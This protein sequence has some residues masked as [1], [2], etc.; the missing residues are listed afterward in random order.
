MERSL[1]NLALGLKRR[2]YDV[3]VFTTDYGGDVNHSQLQIIRTSGLTFSE[4]SN[5]IIKSL[6]N[7]INANSILIYTS[8]A[9]DMIDGI[10]DSIDLFT[11]KGAHAIFRNPT[12]D[13]LHRHLGKGKIKSIISLFDNIVSIDSKSYKEFQSFCPNKIYLIYNG[14]NIS[15]FYQRIPF[16]ER[17]SRI[18]FRSR[19]SQRKNPQMILGLAKILG[20]DVKFYI[21]IT[22]NYKEE[23]LYNRFIKEAK[24]LKN[25]K[26]ISPSWND[27]EV[28]HRTGITLLPSYSEGCSNSILESMATEHICI[29]NDIEENKH[30]LS[31]VGFTIRLE[32]SQYVKVLIDIINNPKNYEDMAIS[33]RRKIIENYS[34][35]NTIEKWIQLFSK[36]D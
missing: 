34:I 22:S 12:S 35:Q 23:N 8:L 14:V 17:A 21:Q 32:T 1:L 30:L 4:W 26:L 9:K 15:E 36:L 18:L 7:L 33:A 6:A 16:L 2:G 13:H 24:T 19:I 29:A 25:I 11:K 5:N 20:D 10:V 31:D 3:L 28:Y 27:I